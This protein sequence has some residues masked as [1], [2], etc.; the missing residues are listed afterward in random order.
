MDKGPFKNG[1]TMLWSLSPDDST[2]LVDGESLMI[3][4]EQSL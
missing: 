2:T 1:V 3:H 4:D